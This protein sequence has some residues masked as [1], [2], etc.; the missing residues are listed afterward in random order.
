MQP[1]LTLVG[2]RDRRVTSAELEGRGALPV[3]GEAMDTVELDRTMSVDEHPEHPSTP[4]RRELHRVTDQRHPP[5]LLF[6]EVGE[7]G[8]FRGGEHPGFVDDHRR[9]RR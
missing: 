4:D 3:V 2:V 6:G 8:E 1:A 7:F 9:T 5:P